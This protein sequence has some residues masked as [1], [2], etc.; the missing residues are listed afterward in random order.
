MHGATS[1]TNNWSGVPPT[2]EDTVDIS[3]LMQYWGAAPGRTVSFAQHS[4]AFVRKLAL[5]ALES[6]LTFEV[7]RQPRP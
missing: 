6:G 7:F 3:I 1:R 4:A 2:L 5:C